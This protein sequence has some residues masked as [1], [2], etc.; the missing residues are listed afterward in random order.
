MAGGSAAAEKRQGAHGF[1]DRD[2]SGFRV[3]AGRDSGRT[4]SPYAAVVGCGS[5]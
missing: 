1:A 2:E 3:P 5:R 4:R